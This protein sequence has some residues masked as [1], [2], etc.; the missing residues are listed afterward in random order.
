MSRIEV[1]VKQLLADK[2]KK[3][4]AMAQINQPT[5][6][7]TINKNSERIANENRKTLMNTLKKPS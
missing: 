6:T 4:E 3:L 7:P 5:F 1:R 2:R